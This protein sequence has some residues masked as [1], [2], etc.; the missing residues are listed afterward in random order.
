[1]ILFKI[2]ENGENVND[3]F[4]GFVLVALRIFVNKVFTK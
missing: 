3:D 2:C 1:M 4:S